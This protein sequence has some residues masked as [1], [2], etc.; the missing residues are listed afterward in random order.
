MVMTEGLV[1]TLATLVPALA[2]ALA[3]EMRLWYVWLK[4][5]PELR[6]RFR[7]TFSW[8]GTGIYV[9]TFF[10]L[11]QEWQLLEWLGTAHHK[12]D[13]AATGVVKWFMIGMVAAVIVPIMALMELLSPLGNS[14]VNEGR[15]SGGDGG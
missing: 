4:R 9:Y 5:H 6:T 1:M 2:I 10:L 7:R 13:E 14:R 12:A 15:D 11:F 3:V 8:I